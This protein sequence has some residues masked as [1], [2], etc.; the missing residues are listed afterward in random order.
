[1]SL[2]ISQFYIWEAATETVFKNICAF[3]LGATFFQFSCLSHQTDTNF[4]RNPDLILEHI[5]I[6][7]EPLFSHRTDIHFPG[8]PIIVHTLFSSRPLCLEQIFPGFL[9]NQSNQGNIRE[10]Y[11][12]LKYQGKIRGE[13]KRNGKSGKNQGN[14]Y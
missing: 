11:F 2:I 10:F 6:F 14:F 8:S 3:F 13:K 7:Q 1:M 9:P 4:P 12:D 5:Q